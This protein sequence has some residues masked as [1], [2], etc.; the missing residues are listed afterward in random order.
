[1]PSFTLL[2]EKVIRFPF[3][4][5][6]SYPHEL[7]HNWWGNSVYVDYE[8]GNWCEGLTAY[9]ADHLMKEQQG[10]GADYRRNALQQYTNHVQDY[11]DFPIA[12]FRSRNNPAEAAIGY[13]KVMMANHMLRKEFGD[14]NFINAY[15]KFYKEYKF[16]NASF[17]D[18]RKCFEDVVGADLRAFFHQWIIRKGAP[19]IELQSASV[20]RRGN[21]Y[22]IDFTLSQNQKEDLFDLRIPIAVYLEND[23]EV[24][25]E[26]IKFKERTRNYKLSFDKRPVRITVDPM[27]DVFRRLGLDEVPTTL[28]QAFGSRDAVLVLPKKSK[29]I[30][31]YKAMADMWQQSQQVQGKTLEV[32][33]DKDM[34]EIPQD[35]AVWILGYEN[36]FAGYVNII[37]KYKGY[38]LPETITRFENLNKSGAVVFVVPNPNNKEMPVCFIGSRIKKAIP[39]LVRKLPHYGKYGYLGFEGEAPTNV[40][41][42]GLPVINSPLTHEF[43]YDGANPVTNAILLPGKPLAE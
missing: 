43:K 15:R 37:E 2:G 10:K 23:N 7:L 38:L 16:K 22:E 11:N 19:E 41:K 20:A 35:K 3:I 25:L 4:L 42:G 27:F 1:M 12:E 30:K 28:S 32:A 29:S 39:G 9:M 5:Y 31:E 24:G 26:T 8:K 17:D 34:D 33:Y 36:K 6:T 18:I 14:E 21:M 13:G 40:L